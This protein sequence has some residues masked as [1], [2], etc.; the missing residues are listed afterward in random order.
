MARAATW[1]GCATARCSSSTGARRCARARAALAHAPRV[2]WAAAV[3]GER[4][5]SWRRLVRCMREAA[6]QS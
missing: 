1:W 6:H 2:R 5:G 3:C 4:E